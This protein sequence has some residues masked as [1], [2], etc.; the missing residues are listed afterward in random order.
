LHHGLP[1]IDALSVGLLCLAAFTASIID[2]MVGGGG[3]I[4]VPALFVI[5]PGAPAP[6][7]LATN[8]FSTTFGAAAAVTR[9]A[10]AGEIP[11]KQTLWPAIV[12]AS[13]SAVGAWA[14]TRV[15][16][17]V[18]RPLVLGLLILVL[19]A[20]L[21]RKDLGAP[22]A[23]IP[24][25]IGLGLTIGA[26]LGFYEGFFGPGT[27]SFLLFLFVALYGFSFLKA[28]AGGRLINFAA[29][30]GALVFFLSQ[31]LVAFEAGIPMAAC[32]L[33]GGSLGSHLAITHGSRWIR[34]VFLVVVVAVIGKFAYDIARG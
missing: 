27:G 29:N 7:L 15:N 31:G 6:V 3:L 32:T 14:V 2:A 13:T 18:I 34:V 8:K 26:A 17:L 11:W 20:T 23:E 19:V 21:L 9:Y 1:Q 5:F 12:A 30:V 10:R 28:S 16:P 22:R 33:L 4:S 25:P 24:R